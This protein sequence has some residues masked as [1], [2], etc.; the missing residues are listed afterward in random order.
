[1]P[2]T[3][4]NQ[5]A[6]SL[7]WMIDAGVDQADVKWLAEIACPPEQLHP[8]AAQRVKEIQDRAYAGL[9]ESYVTPV[10]TRVTHH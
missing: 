5:K 6:Q 10:R 7:K 9:L 3:V 1:M 8:V 2:T 4:V